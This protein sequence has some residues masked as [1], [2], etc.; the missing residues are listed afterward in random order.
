M[1]WHNRAELPAPTSGQISNTTSVCR[2]QVSK[3]D[4]C[5]KKAQVQERTLVRGTI[6]LHLATH[7]DYHDNRMIR[8]RFA[9]TPR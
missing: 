3:Q 2:M 1:P 7:L 8:E 5:K 9:L 6:L 4:T